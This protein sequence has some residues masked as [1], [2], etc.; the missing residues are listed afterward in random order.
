MSNLV[1][2]IMPIYN[3]ERY[4]NEAI[5]S[6]VNQEYVNW[7]LLIINDGST[8]NSKAIIKQYN[9]LRILYFEQTN[10]GVSAARNVG[11]EHMKGTFFCFLDGDD[12]LPPKSI[13][14]RVNLF[15]TNENLTFVDGQVVNW[16]ENYKEKRSIWSPSFEGSPQK[17]L[18]YLTGNSFF[19]ITWMIKREKDTTYLF[20][21][22][23][24][25]AE[26]LWFYI[27]HSEGKEYRYVQEEIY[28]RR[29]VTSS[30][31]SNLKGLAKGYE[32]LK[33]RLIM[34]DINPKWI[35]HYS[36]KIA[37]IMLKSYLK[38]G[39]LLKALSYLP[40]L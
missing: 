36:K 37:S 20:D 30:A 31:M 29:Q 22:N 12:R 1:S 38:E 14:S 28:D 35:R 17:D 6:V 23:M 25:H 34:Y 13:S 16:D 39:N 15:E 19:G 8:D 18:V 21:V 5:D 32:D 7:E 4:L 2:I 3:V 24:T 33:S 26:D 9:D 10:Q 11:L 40:K 27:Q